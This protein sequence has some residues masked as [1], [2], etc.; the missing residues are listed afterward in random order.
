MKTSH[1]VS[2]KYLVALLFIAM[3]HCIFPSLADAKMRRIS[4][5]SK[6][7]LK[8]KCEENGGEFTDFGDS[9]G[10]KK[11]CG[12][13]LKYWCEII[14]DDSGCVGFTPGKSPDPNSPTY[15]INEVLENTISDP[16]P[17]PWGI[18]GWGGFLGLGVFMLIRRRK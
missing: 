6:L 17:F 13:G 8:Q 14:C 5:Y 15:S 12:S 9:W 1:S 18:L 10:C 16:L 7:E 11:R 3:I 2:V 4:K